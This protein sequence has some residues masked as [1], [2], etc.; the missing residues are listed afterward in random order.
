MTSLSQV[1]SVIGAQPS[2]PDSK[3]LEL[4]AAISMSQ[5]WKRQDK[6]EEARAKLVA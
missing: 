6:K 2:V 1:P 4:R 5:L 3:S